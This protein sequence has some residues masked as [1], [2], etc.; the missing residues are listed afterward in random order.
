MNLN[1]S[2]YH[3]RYS[4]TL[5]LRIVRRGGWLFLVR[6]LNSHVGAIIRIYLIV[7]L[8]KVLEKITKLKFRENNNPSIYFNSLYIS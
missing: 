8:L 3:S 6:I 1:Q 5:L 4:L 7:I 2:G